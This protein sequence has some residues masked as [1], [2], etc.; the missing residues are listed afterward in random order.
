MIVHNSISDSQSV[1]LVCRINIWS[2][3]KVRRRIV[4]NFARIL[5]AGRQSWNQACE[6]RPSFIVR[7]CWGLYNQRCFHSNG[8]EGWPDRKTHIFLIAKIVSIS[9]CFRVDSTTWRAPIRFVIW[10]PSHLQYNSSVYR[11]RTINLMNSI[12]SGKKTSIAR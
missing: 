9:I 1:Y 6:R 7:W 8:H 2:R 12:S 4:T 10:W 11:P 5:Y 3:K